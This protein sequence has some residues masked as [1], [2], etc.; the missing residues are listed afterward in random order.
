MCLDHTPMIL[1]DYYYVITFLQTSF[2]IVSPDRL[3]ITVGAYIERVSL[4]FNVCIL[5][6]S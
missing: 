6:G 5:V 3:L 1:A 2:H 4:S